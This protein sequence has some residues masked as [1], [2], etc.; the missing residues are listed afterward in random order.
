MAYLYLTIRYSPNKV[1]K[2]QSVPHV[3]GEEERVI[4]NGDNSIDW[5]NNRRAARSTLVNDWRQSYKNNPS[6]GHSPTQQGV[7]PDEFK[8]QR[9]VRFPD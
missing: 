8:A 9:N 6:N 1:R 3:N 5:L 4:T 7:S 2:W